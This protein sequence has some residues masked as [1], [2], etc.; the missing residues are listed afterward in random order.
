MNAHVETETASRMYEDPAKEITLSA[1]ATKYLAEAGGS[2]EDAISNLVVRLAK[3]KKAR[4]AIAADAIQDA[5]RYRVTV[6]HLHSRGNL[7]RALTNGKD[8]VKSLATGLMRM[9]LDFPLYDGTLLREATVADLDRAI[10]GYRKQAKTMNGYAN[11]LSAIRELT[12]EGTK[13]GDA[14]DN[15]TAQKL[16]EE[17]FG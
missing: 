6:A 12:P 9:A 5:I 1:L 10:D 7:M 4:E 11:W 14:V 17:Q 16:L 13:V 8:Q 15:A 3:D 2:R